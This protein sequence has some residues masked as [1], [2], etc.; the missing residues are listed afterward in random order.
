MD[1]GRLGQ[2]LGRLIVGI[3]IEAIAE[4]VQGV[5]AMHAR[6]DELEGRGELKRAASRILSGQPT[7][8]PPPAHLGAAQVTREIKS[9][10]G[11]T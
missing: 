2:L 9:E 11:R 8:W 3:D 10:G 4:I 7:T 5:S 1:M 6:L